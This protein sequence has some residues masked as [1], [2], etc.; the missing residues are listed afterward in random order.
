[1]EKKKFNDTA[2]NALIVGASG[3]SG[4]ALLQTLVH[5][6][7]VAQIFALGRSP[8]PFSNS[9]INS[10]V[11]DFE[12]LKINLSELKIDVVFCCLGTTIKKA[13]HREVFEKVD[14][15]FVVQLARLAKAHQVPNFAVV[16]SIGAKPTA[17]SFYLRTKRLMEKEL[18]SL[19][20]PNTF[21]F[22][23]S[24]LVGKRNEF[25]LLERISMLFLIGL[26]PLLVG[27]FRRYRPTKVTS[28]AKAMKYFALHESGLQIIENEIIICY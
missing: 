20:I 8:L 18:I 10:Q 6:D 11:V 23:P 27:A 12:H 1:M 3:L 22:R 5:D 24:I 15:E 13:K 21:I 25:R 26:R 28:L 9:K 19:G 2:I 7:R 16:S 17:S 4:T 14:K